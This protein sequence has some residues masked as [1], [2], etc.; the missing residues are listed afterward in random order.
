MVLPTVSASSRLEVFPTMVLVE[1]V[2]I[3]QDEIGPPRLAFANK[4]F[5]SFVRKK[6]AA[7]WDRQ[8]S[9][10]LPT[11]CTH[12]PGKLSGLREQ[13]EGAGLLFAWARSQIAAGS[14]RDVLE[15]STDPL[16]RVLAIAREMRQPD[17]VTPK[18]PG[19]FFL[20]SVERTGS[21]LEAN[22]A[23]ILARMPADELS[24]TRGLATKRVAAL[25][26][27]LLVGFSLVLKLLG[28]T[29]LSD[30]GFG[31]WT[32]AW[33]HNTSQWMADPYTFSHLLHGIFFYWF[34]LPSRRWLT[35]GSR[36][37]IACLIEAS[38]EILENS[39]FIIDRYRTTTASLDYYG[40]SI[41]NSTFDL[42]AAMAGFW[43]ASKCNWK[44]L[45]LAVVLIELLSLYFIRDN[46]TLNVLM[47]FHPSEAIKQWQ[48]GT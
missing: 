2:N 5:I 48:M 47:L 7:A 30:S 44:W 14:D 23:V 25:I 35:V 19:D 18:S 43:L 17:R 20:R 21:Y 39:P 27:L 1:N 15:Q 9:K 8:V 22:S 28:R 16:I 42:I 34:L 6:R 32:G 45:L 33:T 41:L 4:Q 46:L 31:V 3:A 12:K 10:V 26:V 36:F 11:K 13:S 24:E 37:F 40:D 38:W 29:F